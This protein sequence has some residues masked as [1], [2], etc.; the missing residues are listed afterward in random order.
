MHTA[1]GF[2]VPLIRALKAF[3][4]APLLA[5]AIATGAAA[6]PEADSLMAGR[7][8]DVHFAV[9]CD[10]KSQPRFDAAL[11]ALHSFWYGQ[12]LKEFT[13]LSEADPQCAMSYWGMAM[14]VWNQLWAPPRPDNLKKGLDAIEKARAITGKS[15]READYIDALATFYTD[16]DKLDH[17]TRAGAYAAKM[18]QV[19]QRYPDD[20]E[21]Q[22]FYA[23]SLLASAD[24]LDKTYKNQIAGGEML[25]KLFAQMPEHPAVSHYIIHAYDYPALAD[26]ALVAALKYAVCVTVVPHAVHMPS[27]TY[28]LLG[29][30]QDTI[31]ANIA[32]QEA[33]SDRGTP[34]DRI[35]DL[36]Y[37]VYA[38]LQLGQD[39]KA[40]Q[41]V[42][43]ALEID[44]ELTARKHDSGLRARPFGI[45]AM[46][47]R[48]TLERHDWAAAAE[49]PVRASR[50]PYAE[51]V[52]HFARAVGFARSGRPD[53]AQAEVDA[54]AGLQKTLTDAKNL[55]WARQVGIERGMASAWVARALGRD[56]EAVS[57]MQDAA[58]TEESSETHDALSPGPIGMTAH[59]ALGYLLLE[60][61]R[62][63]E[64]RKAFEASLQF[65]RN[66]LQSYAGAAN[67][68][69][70][71]GDARDARSYYGKLLELTAASE[72][73]RPEIAAAKAYVKQ[74]GK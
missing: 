7:G 33:E 71:A 24:P 50:Y 31:T 40:K 39:A 27:H 51:A 18:Q 65:S 52:S 61:K 23:L 28:V 2:V 16:A 74:D 45:A 47:A 72:E 30:W 4:L 29:R 53:Q 62:P 64:A 44:N 25:E 15:P 34:E 46:E 20:R 21:A 13:A 43:L 58:R 70:L 49:L 67:A 5:A 73:A 35:H 14:S 1:A 69:A 17:P 48:W 63:A 38:Y 19:A 32:G 22:I 36:D 3:G 66:R 60:L 26:R 54:L 10:A 6:D 8:K 9:S 68:A 57:L 59:E 42:D 12:A 41:V 55:Y 37:L 56:E 11:A